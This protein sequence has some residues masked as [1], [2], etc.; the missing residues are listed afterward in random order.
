MT[1]LNSQVKLGQSFELQYLKKIFL[2]NF[3][4]ILQDGVFFFIYRVNF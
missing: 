4:K 1:S 2:Y 3:F